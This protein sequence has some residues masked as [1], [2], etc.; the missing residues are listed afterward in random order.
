M[1]LNKKIPDFLKLLIR[2]NNREWFND[3]KELYL[4]AKLLFEEFVEALI[5]EVSKFD[6]RVSNL[7]V[8]DCSFRIYRDVRFSKDKTPYKIHFGAYISESGRKSQFSG[9]YIHIE[10]DRNIIAGG[11]HMPSKEILHAVRTDIYN[12]PDAIKS[13]MQQADF[14]SHFPVIHG[15]RLKTAPKGFDKTFADLELIQPKSYDFFK[16][17][18]DEEIIDDKYFDSCIEEFKILLPVN[19]YFNKIIDKCI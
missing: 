13:I 17:V 11:L 10:P 16:E 18:S 4:E 12:K 14:K 19:N 3:N 7:Q 1:K 2:N 9:Y 5:V 6:S 15:E 8:K